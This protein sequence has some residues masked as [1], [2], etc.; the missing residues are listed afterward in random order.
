MVSLRGSV[1]RLSAAVIA[2]CISLHVVLGMAALRRNAPTF[3]EP[4]HLAAGYSALSLRDYRVN[5]TEHPPFAEMWSAVPLLAL[6]PS[7]DATGEYWR[8]ARHDPYAFADRFVFANRVP[9]DT[10]MNAGRIMTLL[11]SV[12]LGLCIFWFSRDIFGPVAGM[13]GI[14]LWSLSPLFLAHG[15]LV[16]TDMAL[17]LFYTSTLYAAFRYYRQ[18]GSYMT[19]AMGGL[20]L[21]LLLASKYSAVIVFPALALGCAFLYFSTPGT[22]RQSR[23][24]EWVLCCVIAVL[25]V[26]VIYQ[27]RP[28]GRYYFPGIGKVF[29]DVSGSRSAF[30]LGSHS[31]TGW[32]Y[33]F[34][35]VAFLKT[36]LPFLVLAA[37][38]LCDRRL[39]KKDVISFVLFP[40]ALY[41][42]AACFSHVQ[43]GQRHIMPV[44]PFLTVIAAGA[45][46]SAA[47][48]PA[49]LAVACLLVWF[50]AGTLRQ[51]PWY[52]SYFNELIGSPHNGYAYLTDSNL[53]WGQGLK[54]L[55]VWLKTQQVKGIYL[56]YFGTADPAAYDISYIPAGGDFPP[57]KPL[58]CGSAITL[59]PLDRKL[60]AVSATHLQST[61]FTDKATFDFLKA[62]Q[63]AAVIAHSIFVYDLTSRPAEYEKLMEIVR[64]TGR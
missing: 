18:P 11:L 42:T 64:A 13:A 6:H 35:V 34:P 1:N 8:A 15:T 30:L 61:Y 5:T 58:R 39:W 31:R 16:T 40:A 60:V 23:I 28:L 41:F 55:S 22:Q 43:I 56:C 10:M 12:L 25:V 38:G 44:Y 21:G 54:E 51:S 9:A 24:A 2:V 59:G 62:L 45:V 33:Y 47:A 52:I 17:T 19:L 14:V 53:D 27:F 32:W 26:I 48:L 20:S 3:D 63:P 7:F 36:P 49:R 57:L 50:G 46:A 4:I 37:I 29:H